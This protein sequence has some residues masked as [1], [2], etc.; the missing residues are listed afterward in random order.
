[1]SD[2]IARDR[3]V[4]WHPFTQSALPDELLPIAG[5]RGAILVLEDGREIIDGISSWWCTLHGH[6]HPKL[7]QAV[8][9]QADLLD[10]VLFAGC[11]HAPAVD[12]A[13]QVLSA[14]PAGFSKIFYSDNGSTAIEV[15]L[16]MAVQFWSNHKQRRA[17]ILA[18]EGSYHGDTFGAMAVGARGL[19]SAP[20]EEMLFCVERLS[21]DGTA[22]DLARCEELCAGGTIAAFIFEP[23]VQGAAGM[24]MY[25]PEVIDRYQAICRKYGVLTIADEVMTGFGRTGPL[26][27]SSVL[28][29]PPDIMCLSKGLTGGVMPLAITAC[30]SEVFEAFRSPDFA[31]TFFHGHTFT[32]NPIACAVARASLELT[33]SDACSAQR[34]FIEQA[35]VRCAAR[36]REFPGIKDVRVRGTILAFDVCVN[37][38]PGY[39]SSIRETAKRFFIERGILLRPLGEVVYCMPPYCVSADQ[40]E[41][42]HA[43][44]VEF[45]ELQCA[46]LLAAH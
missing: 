6:A 45:A 19:F 27:V 16:K 42:I 34:E 20:F 22:A 26:F 33:T 9:R 1:V 32:A 3:R 40:L 28:V 29:T 4:V 24:R 30:T 8:A 2:L 23:S 13:E 36:L 17:G 15:A 46:T 5:A 35:H 10:H 25:P 38:T 39:A 43:A 14:V 21:T 18:L 31:K 11:T 37:D 12:L 41:R 7:V 44:M